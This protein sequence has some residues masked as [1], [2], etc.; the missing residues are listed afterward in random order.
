MDLLSGQPNKS[1]QELADWEKTPNRKLN[2]NLLGT[3]VMSNLIEVTKTELRPF[4]ITIPTADGEC[5]AY[6]IPLMVPMIWEPLANQWLLTPEAE[7]RIFQH[8]RWQTG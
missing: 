3:N 7:E 1:Y 4:E 8:A 5:V 6:T 2:T